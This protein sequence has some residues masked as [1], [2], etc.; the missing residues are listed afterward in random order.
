MHGQVD[1]TVSGT[2]PGDID[3]WTPHVVDEDDRG[4]DRATPHLRFYMT[5]E[6]VFE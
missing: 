3:E 4:R 5:R 2:L 1:S 6:L